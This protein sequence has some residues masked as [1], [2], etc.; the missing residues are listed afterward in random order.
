[1][2]LTTHFH[3]TSQSSSG[4][5]TL[6]EAFKQLTTLQWNRSL[7]LYYPYCWFS[8][9]DLIFSPPPTWDEWLSFRFYNK[10]KYPPRSFAQV[11]GG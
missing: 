6:V 7:F 10:H 2:Q 3:N 4:N 9:H 1:Q 8:C 5:G 11:L